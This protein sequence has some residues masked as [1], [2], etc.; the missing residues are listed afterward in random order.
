MY[1]TLYVQLPSLLIHIR[2]IHTGR[3]FLLWSFPHPMADGHLCCF[4]VGAITNNTAINV[5]LVSFGEFM[6]FCRS[7][8]LKLSDVSMLS[9]GRNS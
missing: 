9:F 6:H 7:G 8:I 5:P 3:P 1:G 4:L 2:G